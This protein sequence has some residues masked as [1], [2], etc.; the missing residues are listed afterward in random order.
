MG[1]RKAVVVV[2]VVGDGDGLLLPLIQIQRVRAVGPWRCSYYWWWLQLD[3][4]KVKKMR[5]SEVDAHLLSVHGGSEVTLYYGEIA[6]D[7]EGRK[8]EE[9]QRLDEKEEEKTRKTQRQFLVVLVRFL[10][11]SLHACSL[12]LYQTPH[13]QSVLPCHLLGLYSHSRLYCYHWFHFF[14]ELDSSEEGLAQ[15]H[16]LADQT[17]SV[18]KE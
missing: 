13:A 2:V 5:E 14:F 17:L 16:G 1:E 11:L 4:K 15:A 10:A 9:E 6:Y 8:T 18:A 12:H 3:Q 7:E